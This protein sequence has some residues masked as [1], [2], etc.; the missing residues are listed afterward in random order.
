MYHKIALVGALV[1]S[2]S[3][4]YLPGKYGAT[5]SHW[6]EAGNICQF[7][8]GVDNINNAY[9]YKGRMSARVECKDTSYYEF[10]RAVIVPWADDAGNVAQP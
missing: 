8:G 10:H 9:S 5:E 6:N 3:A 1:V 7:H 2:L 4:C